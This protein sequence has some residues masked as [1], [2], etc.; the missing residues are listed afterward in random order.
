MPLTPWSGFKCSYRN[1]GA[2]NYVANVEAI[3]LNVEGDGHR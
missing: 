2:V 1:V 3:C